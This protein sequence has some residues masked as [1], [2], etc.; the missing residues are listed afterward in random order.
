MGDS[1]EAYFARWDGKSA[2]QLPSVVQ[3]CWSP[4]RLCLEALVLGVVL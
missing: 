3:R 1:V 2:R 4:G